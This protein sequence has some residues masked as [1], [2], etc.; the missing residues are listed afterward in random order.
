MKS[1]GQSVD[2]IMYSS[3]RGPG[4]NFVFFVDA[5]YIG[6]GVAPFPKDAKFRL[7]RVEE[8][9]IAPKSQGQLLSAE[10]P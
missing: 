3:S 6:A 2:G 4:N 8:R 1:N 5:R 10:V 9:P 7:L